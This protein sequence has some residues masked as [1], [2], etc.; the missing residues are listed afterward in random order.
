MA[1][2][3]RVRSLKGLPS[4]C[5]VVLRRNIGASSVVAKA[6]AAKPSD[7]IQKLFLEKINEYKTKATKLKDGE[8]VESN[9]EIEGRRK[10][11]MD[12]LKRRYGNEDMTVFPKFSFEK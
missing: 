2:A 7:P 6:A 1:F 8:L 11:E 4:C 5:N 9:A 3:P 12:N 10:F